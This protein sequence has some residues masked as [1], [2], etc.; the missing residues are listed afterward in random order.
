MRPST[1][2]GNT[3]PIGS[4]IPNFMFANRHSTYDYGTTNKNKEKSYVVT[5]PKKEPECFL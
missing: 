3:E 4:I 5:I 1:Q 2:L